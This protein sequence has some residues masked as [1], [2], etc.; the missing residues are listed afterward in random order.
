MGVTGGVAAYKSLDIVSQ[1]VK[2]DF[3]VHVI[4]TENA[5][6]FM[7]E[8]P[9]KSLT[10]NPVI[11]SLFDD[12][13]ESAH[14]H[15]ELARCDYFLIVPATANIIGKLANGIVDDALSST[16]IATTAPI[17][18]A[19]AMNTKMYHHPAVQKNLKTLRDWGLHII[20]PSSGRLACGDIG[21][22]KL[23]DFQTIMDHIDY[24][25]HRSNQYEGK[26]VLVALGATK[27]YLDP[28][29]YLSNPS[30]GKMGLA[31]ARAFRN[32][33]AEVRVLSANHDIFESTGIEYTY[34]EST[35]DLFKKA[36]EFAE[37][38]DIYVSAAAV[39]DYEAKEVLEHKRK[40]TGKVLTLELQPSV[41]VLDYISKNYS[42]KTF[43][44]AAETQDFYD[45]ALKKLKKKDLD[46]IL[47]NDVSRND[48]GFRADDNEATLITRDLN[49]Y[50]FK[51]MEKQKLAEEVIKQ[52]GELDVL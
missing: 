45:H 11:S 30:T 52:L 29:R 37:D 27:N 15:I 3:D 14:A 18:I 25:T 10:G 33:G 5:K 42:I 39:A 28:V 2:M 40:K 13:N 26:K 23:A 44:F 24:V 6:E 49:Q 38:Y 1:L 41:D 46:C 20:E 19:P 48:I 8:I 12:K 34:I 9:F 21:D 43:G 7:G 51:K 17:M 16:L 32:A 47:V 36:T 50:H 4:L 35:Q 22:G 31:F